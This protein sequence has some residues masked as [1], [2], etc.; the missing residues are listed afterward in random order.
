MG[1]EV[2][3]APFVQQAEIY[4]LAPGWSAVIGLTSGAMSS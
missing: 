1:V 3:L 4:G 2:A